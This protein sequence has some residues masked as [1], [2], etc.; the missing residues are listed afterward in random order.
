MGMGSSSRRGRGAHGRCESREGGVEDGVRVVERAGGGG[1][2][3]ERSVSSSSSS[4]ASTG[5]SSSNSSS[6]SSGGGWHSEM[7]LD[8]EHPLAGGIV[9]LGKFD[10]LHVGHRA[11]AVQAAGMG[12][13]CVCMLSFAGMAEVLGWEKRLPLVAP[14]DRKRV[15][16]LWQ[17]LCQGQPI[18]EFFLD[19]ARIR[20]LSP[21]DFIVLLAQQLSVKGIVAGSNYRFGFRAAGT[22]SDLV[23][24]G[25]RHGVHVMIVDT[26]TDAHAHMHTDVM[27]DSDLATVSAAAAAVSAKAAAAAAAVEAAEETHVSSTRVRQQLCEGNVEGVA[28]LIARRHRILLSLSASSLSLSTS[29]PPTH[30]ADRGSTETSDTSSSSNSSG[31]STSSSSDTSTSSNSSSGGGGHGW[32]MTVGKQ[33]LLN[34]APGEGRYKC[35]VLAHDDDEEG[36]DGRRHRE[37][38]V[39]VGEVEVGEAHLC[40]KVQ[41]AV[42]PP[43]QLHRWTCLMLEI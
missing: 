31:T 5:S 17:P 21:E 16:E 10:A 27:A 18:R 41:Q 12:G 42:L 24:L 8:E 11:L 28:A 30:N 1:S 22:A 4:H 23:S 43:V 29:W 3:G 13:T 40:V 39:G 25:A 37:V 38:L 6:S 26:V 35:R 14:C 15:L 32:R 7:A 20:S 2:E 19:F 9:A 33:D 36:E 34:L